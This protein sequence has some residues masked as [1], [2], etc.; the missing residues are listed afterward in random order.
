MELVDSILMY[1]GIQNLHTRDLV[2]NMGLFVQEVAFSRYD[3]PSEMF[4]IGHS[5]LS[6]GFVM[7]Q[8]WRTVIN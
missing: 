6:V 2:E 5:L 4:Y 8:G 3:E 1:N 7:L